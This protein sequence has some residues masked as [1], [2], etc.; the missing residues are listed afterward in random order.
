MNNIRFLKPDYN[1]LTNLRRQRIILGLIFILLLVIAAI[2]LY[3]RYSEKRQEFKEPVVNHQFQF[4]KIISKEFNNIDIKKLK[5]EINGKDIIPVVYLFPKSINKAD[6]LLKLKKSF[7][8]AGYRVRKIVNLPD[9]SGFGFYL[10]NNNPASYQIFFI[11][12]NQRSDL[13]KYFER[14]FNKPP[15]LALIIN[16][17]GYDTSATAENI[18]A[19]PLDLTIAITP[20]RE[21]S[22]WAAEKAIQNNKEVIIHMPME[23]RNPDLLNT[24][25]YMLADTMAEDSVLKTLRKSVRELPHAVGMDNYMGSKATSATELMYTLMNFLKKSGLFFIDNLNSLESVGYQVAKKQNVPVGVRNI[26]ISGNRESIRQQLDRAL[27]LAQKSGKII[28]V[29]RADNSTLMV[30]KQYLNS[31]KFDNVELCFASE[32]VS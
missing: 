25:A 32:L 12:K 29:A 15:R 24:E 21:A 11:K 26:F 19:L 23:P 20:G 6:L 8:S 5:L 16:S 22:Q 17:F 3:W 1:K 4:D 7:S 10:L 28:A 30:I 13:K 27:I 14:V 2:T 18:L 31:D 9:G